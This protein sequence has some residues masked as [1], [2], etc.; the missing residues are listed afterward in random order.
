[1]HKNRLK[2]QRFRSDAAATAGARIVA[3][4]SG[5]FLSYC[6]TN[7][8]SAAN[9]GAFFFMFAL[10]N[11]AANISTLGFPNIVLRIVSGNKSSSSWISINASWSFIFSMV[12]LISLSTAT[13]IIILALNTHYIDYYFANLA[14]FRT[15]IAVGAI[16]IPLYAVCIIQA[17]AIQGLH[18]FVWSIIV[19]RIGIPLSAGLLIFYFS[20][21]N[22]ELSSVKLSLYLVISGLAVS[23]IAVVFWTSLPKFSMAKPSSISVSGAWLLWQVL[24]INQLIAWGGQL[25]AAAY[26]STDEV[27]LLAIAQRVVTPISLVLTAVNMVAAPRLAQLHKQGDIT[28]AKHLWKYAQKLTLIFALPAICGLLVLNTE[29]MLLFGPEYA[30]SG[31]LL[32]ILAIGQLINCATGPVNYILSMFNQ[33]KTLRNCVLTSGLVFALL[34]LFLVPKWGILGAAIAISAGMGSQN[35]LAWFSAR[36]L[37]KQSSY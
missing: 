11:L 23:S 5:L 6:V 30:S 32:A 28:S 37:L 14:P 7:S 18:R 26:T 34:L 19:G 31:P 1:M 4:F 17:S 2:R 36:N 10:A 29:I 20:S 13:A 35:I 22:D 21:E 8:T 25:Y 33:D 9:A 12:C 16:M 27:A 3:A 15:T 24:I